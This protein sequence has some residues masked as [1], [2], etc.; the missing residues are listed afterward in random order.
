[1]DTLLATITA[2]TSFALVVLGIIELSRGRWFV[3][4]S[5]G[6]IGIVSSIYSASRT[7]GSMA[8]LIDK[9]DT[10]NKKLDQAKKTN[11]DILAQ[12]T[13]PSKSES[14]D[15]A[16]VPPSKVMPVPANQQQDA[17]LQALRNEYIL[18]HDGITSAMMA[19]LQ[20]PDEN[21]LNVRLKQLHQTWSVRVSPDR[22]NVS[23]I[24]G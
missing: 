17:I 13:V 19:G 1:M 12:L 5:L 7:S 4:V 10:A 3:F 11:D 6:L 22:T 24:P 21:W 15:A 8:A 23:T 18:S 20:W 9:L 14:H 2:L 16:E